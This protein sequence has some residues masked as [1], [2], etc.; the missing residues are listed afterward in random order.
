MMENFNDDFN[1]FLTN[2]PPLYDNYFITTTTINSVITGSATTTTQTTPIKSATTTNLVFL[3][4]FTTII[5]TITNNDNMNSN[6]NM[7]FTEPFFEDP[8]YILRYGVF[9]TTILSIAYGLVF[10]IGVLGNIAVVLVIFKTTRMRSPTNQFI[11]NLA[12]ADLLVN[13]LC[14]PFTLIGN[15]FPAW[16]LG[17]FF[18]KFV[19]YS[20]GVSVS[21]SVNTLMA[22]SIERCAAISFPLSGIMTPRQYKVVVSII[23]LIALT[24]NLPWLFVFTLEPLGIKGSHAV[25]CTELWPSEESGNAYFITANL[26]I[27]YLG[28]LTVITFCYIIIW[29]KV[30]T[31]SVPGEQNICNKRNAA[32]NRIKI[33]VIKMVFV[34]VITFAISWFPLY[35]I[36][37]IVKFTDL[38]SNENI[39][40]V[41]LLILPIAQWLGASNSCIN[42]ILYAFMN[43]KFRIG[44]KNLIQKSRSHT[45]TIGWDNDLNNVNLKIYRSDNFSNRKKNLVVKTE[46][47]RLSSSVQ[48]VEY[49]PSNISSELDDDIVYKIR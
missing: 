13:F 21:A 3:K 15:L 20:Q 7:S 1:L 9:I 16:I 2:Q 40:T 8:G 33:K 27:C 37:C 49:N 4:N 19:S 34:V 6:S 47:T 42:P 32:V 22:I 25:V 12:I 24:I 11:A 26:T 36:F 30:A 14:L 35:T 41:I 45:S 38:L 10:I 17:E 29:R 5:T 28:P 39:Q 44:F 31:R 18:C 43:H 48:H 23:W 46:S